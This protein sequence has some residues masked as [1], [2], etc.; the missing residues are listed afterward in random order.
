MLTIQLPPKKL[1]TKKLLFE[2]SLELLPEQT[3]IKKES[4]FS[5]KTQPENKHSKKMGACRERVVITPGTLSRGHTPVTTA[6]SLKSC[7]NRERVTP[8]SAEPP[9][10]LSHTRGRR[11]NQT[12]QNRS[13]STPITT[14]CTALSSCQWHLDDR[15]GWPAGGRG[16]GWVSLD[17]FRT[18]QHLLV[19]GTSAGDRREGG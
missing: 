4:W 16:W 2:Y 19:G 5:N 13:H 3:L 14:H 15:P 9:R 1:K 12:E 17:S 10:P 7:L 8:Q 11:E 18:V 6:N